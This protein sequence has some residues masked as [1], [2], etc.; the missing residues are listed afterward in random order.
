[1]SAPIPVPAPPRLLGAALLVLTS[2]GAALAQ[3]PNTLTVGDTAITEGSSGSRDALFVVRLV[4]DANCNTVTVRYFTGNGTAVQPSDYRATSGTLT[5]AG[6]QTCL[7]SEIQIVRVPV[8]GDT[9]FEGDEIFYLYLDRQAS[10]ASVT[11]FQGVGTIRND[12]NEVRI[13]D[14]RLT[15]GNGG[16]TNAELTVSLATLAATTI[17]V[18]WA[19][20]PDTATDGV[21]YLRRSGTVSFPARVG[22]RTIT[23]P[24]VGDLSDEPSE[25]FFVDLSNPVGASLGDPQ[26]VVTILDDDAPPTLSVGDATAVEGAGQNAAQI[27]VT[28]SVAS[29]YTV[30]VGFAASP[31]SA[32]AGGDYLASPYTISF[33][34]G[35]TRADIWISLVDDALHEASEFFLVDLQQPSLATIADGRGVVTIEDDDPAPSLRISDVSVSEGDTGTRL[36]NFTITQSAVTGRSTGIVYR[37]DDGTARAGQDYDLPPGS[38]GGL[39]FDAIPAGQTTRTIS[40]PV[41]GDLLDELDETFSVVITQ[42]DG[43]SL[44]DGTGVATIVDDDATPS[45]SVSDVTVTEGS[46]GTTRARFTVSLSAASGRT[47]QVAWATANDS[48]LAGADYTATSGTLV[49]GRGTSLSVDVDVTGDALD[50]PNERFFLELSAPVAATI[51]DGRGVGTII[52]DDLAPTLSVGDARIAEGGRQLDF[53]VALSAPSGRVIGV[54]YASRDGSATAGAD[55]TATSGRLELPAGLASATISVPVLDDARDEPDE[56]LELTLSAP[57]NASLGDALGVGTIV[58]D[59]APPTISITGAQVTEGNA[60]STDARLLVRLS[61]ASG[62]EITVRWATADDTA[63][64]GLDYTAGTGTLRFPAGTT[65]QAIVVPVLGDTL[66]EP[67]ERFDV[68]LSAPSNASLGAATASVLIADDDGEP[69]LSV[70]DAIVVEDTAGARLVFT[71]RLAAASGLAVGVDYATRDLDAT[72]GADYTATSGR[73]VFAPGA[74]ALE[75]AVPVLADALDEDDEQLALD[76]TNPSN[77]VI[78]DALGVGTITDDDATPSLSIAD[79]SVVEG[80]GGTVSARFT[81]ALSAPSGRTVRVSFATAD[82]GATAGLDYTAAS[83]RLSLARGTRNRS[84]DVVVASDALDEL[85]ERFVVNLSAPENASLADA[86]AVGTIVDDDLPPSLSIGDVTIAEGDTGSRQAVFSVTLSAASGRPITVDATTRDDTARAGVDYLAAAGTLRL[87]A[88]T[89]RAAFSVP[90]LGDV[91]D[92]ADERFLVALSGAVDASIADGEAIGTITD[93]DATPSLSIADVAIV[94]GDTGSRAAVLT[95]RLSAASGRAV[96]VDWATADGEARAGADYTAASGRLELAPGATSAELRV[97]VLSDALDEDDERLFVRLSGASAATIADGEAT[98]TITDDDDAPSLS[99][100]DV[101]VAEGAAGGTA[102]ARFRIRLSAPSGRAISVR[103]ATRDDTAR[104]GLDYTATTGTTR[105]AAG[106]LEQLVA[107]PILGD[108]LDEDDERLELELSQPS[109][110]TIGRGLAVGTIVD[111]DAPPVA[112]ITGATVVEGDSGTVDARF[113][114]RLSAPSALV[115]TVDFGTVDGTATGGTDY[116]AA[117]G[118]LRFAPGELER[119][120]VVQVNGDAIDEADERFSVELRNPSNLA[121]GASQATG[122]ITDDDAPPSVSIADV[123]VVE[124]NAGSTLVTVSARLSAASGQPSSVA[125]ATADGT[126]TAPSDYVAASGRLAFAVGE[127]EASVSLEVRGDTLSEPTERFELRLSAPTALSIGD[128][129]AAIDI[130][131][132]DRAP[133]LSVVDVA[134]VEGDTGRREAVFLVRLSAPSGQTVGVRA[135]SRDGTATAPADYVATTARLSFAPGVTEQRFVVPVLGDA[136]DED[137]ERFEV[138]LDQA[139]VPILDALAEGRI[140]DDDDPPVVSIADARRAE[141]DTGAA[142]LVFTASLSAPSGRAID[143]AWATAD[144]SAVAPADYT[145]GRGTLR[146]APGATTAAITVSVRGDTVDESDE[147]L[148]VNL[149]NPVNASLGRGR[150]V[151][152]IVDDDGAPRL[153]LAGDVSALEGS[154]SPGVLRFEV[155]LTPASGQ[156]VTVDYETIDGTALAG[157]DFTAARGSLRFAPGETRHPIELALTPDALDEP[158]ETLLVR[159]SAPSNAALGTAEATGTIRDDDDPPALSVDDLRAPEG[160]SGSRVVAVEVRLS[161][162]SGREV[163]VELATADGSATAPDDY[164]ATSARLVFAPGDTVRRVDLPIRGDT[165][166]EPD[167]TLSVRLSA[168]SQASLGDPEAVVTIGDDDATPSLSIADL[169]RP[170]SATE[171]VLAVALSAPSGQEVGVDWATED[172][173]ARDGRDYR[174]AGGRLIFPPGTTRQTLRIELLPDDLDEPDEHFVVVLSA[175]AAAALADNRAT[176]RVLDDDDAPV[177]RLEDVRVQEGDTGSRSGL[178]LARLSAPSG[179]EIRAEYATD[180]V[181]ATAGVDYTPVS[182]RLVFAPGAVTAAIA[183]PVLGDTEDEADEDVLL[184]LVRV[185]NATIATDTARLTIVDDDSGPD[186]GVLLS[187]DAPAVVGAPLQVR[188][189]VSNLG[190]NPNAG[191][192]LLTAM[193][194]E[195]LELGRAGGDGWDCLLR[196]RNLRCTT[197]ARVPSLESAPGLTWTGTVGAAGYPELVLSATVAAD[198]DFNPEND[199]ARLPVAVIGRADLGVELALD[200]PVMAGAPARVMVTVR[201]HGPT[202]VSELFLVPTLGAGLGAPRLTPETGAWS[203]ADG[204]W[205]GL[206]LPSGGEA[207]LALAVDVAPTA[208]GTLGLSVDVGV[209]DGLVDGEPSNDRARLGLVVPDAEACDADGLSDAQERAAGTDPC[210]ADTDGDG[211]CDGAVAVEGVCAAGEDLD[212]S[213]TVEFGETDPRRADTDGDGLSDGLER[214][215]ENPTDP[216]APD[217]DQDGLCDGPVAVAERCAAGEDLN[218]NGRV[219]EGETDPNRF[220]TDG[221]GIGDG[222]ER[223]R[224]TD[225]LQPDDDPFGVGCECGALAGG[226]V[227]RGPIRGADG[228]GLAGL[229]GLALL[230]RRRRRGVAA[231]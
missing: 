191:P 115:A 221:G 5:F 121:L 38:E 212:G 141:G 181:D 205:T 168:P 63:T 138:E 61:A 163:T 182:G 134:V 151:G 68:T 93:D 26:A 65:T 27:P 144:D 32:V 90:V 94:E 172:A 209:V 10:N 126:A 66:D 109:G 119:T 16:T 211:L 129:V 223:E 139:T 87:A 86:R 180:D 62:R 23:V 78:V 196:D 47:V 187:V 198:G 50:E 201:N 104:A 162:P 13:A 173:E 185:E 51:A 92:E 53:T 112:S 9:S 224:G 122:L 69:A 207:R 135:T 76:L 19:T 229:L 33:P 166:D 124:G 103:H 36:A 81:V 231:G 113:L 34:P 91:L 95:V 56:T 84:F 200:G 2:A 70:D 161:A 99:V 214:L 72:A 14:L 111:D 194:P 1:M 136:L 46:G 208:Q 206:A 176:V 199:H 169:E 105:F 108:E 85:D 54:D 20:A 145:A 195:G 175:P 148:L 100:A 17:T 74:T 152:T 156:T 204:R 101:S 215:G 31:G 226:P 174:A 123:S 190:P 213:G 164:T 11:D 203:E 125:F 146:F 60:G 222:Q 28:L 157:R 184:R 24:I 188:A 225:P 29:G 140:T 218:A 49:F 228:L 107:V 59:D 96:G 82:D 147:T 154:A 42:V 80:T 57:T 165:L 178:V 102:T 73:L 41:R 48:A 197:E 179:R 52:D 210:L 44:S 220:D 186:L 64:A 217:T 8:Y 171:A 58:D 18:D 128:G 150:A 71:V 227:R 127:T 22:V 83:G 114:V 193:V 21:D 88:G 192:I 230:A 120:I 170:E 219:D 15:E 45:L 40:V 153:S 142:D 7:S 25:R 39:Y 55:Y 131:D 143:V 30:S 155:V 37:I 89:T 149:S 106:E 216:R 67:N 160:D 167:E 110:A 183:V 202:A 137:D 118:S 77:A 116:T 3:T 159:L 177:L 4:R 98:V 12:D 79:V 43:A 133:G 75:V 132:D 35:Q 189:T 117:T 97:Q 158:D 6:S 130:V